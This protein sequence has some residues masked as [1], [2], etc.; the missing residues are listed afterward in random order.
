M[1][2]DKRG[3]TFIQ[4]TA[5]DPLLIQ[6]YE[7][8]SFSFLCTQAVSWEEARMRDLLDGEESLGGRLN[9]DPGPIYIQNRMTS[10]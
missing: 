9:F 3:K 5:F 1:R 7:N 2:K 10:L 8:I 6:C 4:G